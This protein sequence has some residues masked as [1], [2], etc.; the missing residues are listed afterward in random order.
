M[1]PVML[2]TEDATTVP[3]AFAVDQKGILP[4]HMIRRKIV[5]AWDGARFGERR[6]HVVRQDAFLIHGKGER[7]GRCILCPQHDRKR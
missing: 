6:D 7:H 3:L 5:R 2:R 1:L 4:D